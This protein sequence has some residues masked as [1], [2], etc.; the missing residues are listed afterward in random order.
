M[1]N[2]INTALLFELGMDRVF[3]FTPEDILLYLT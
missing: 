3:L 1:E 2:H